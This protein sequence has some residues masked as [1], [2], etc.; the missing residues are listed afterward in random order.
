VIAAHLM[1]FPA[2]EGILQLAPAGAV[3]TAAV[4]A[5]LAR[6]RGLAGRR[7]ARQR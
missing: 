7:R 1:G 4:I 5:V 6:V 3:V 2:E